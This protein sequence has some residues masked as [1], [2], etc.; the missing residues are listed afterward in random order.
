MIESDIPCFFI[1]KE[2]D[3]KRENVTNEVKLFYEN[4]PFPNY[5]GC[6]TLTDLVSQ[7]E[8]SYFPNWLN[9]SIPYKSKVLEI[10]CG[11]GLLSNYLSL[12]SRTVFGTDICNN[13]LDLANNFKLKNGIDR[14]GFY[15]MNLFYPVFKKESFDYIICNGVL[16]HTN[17]PIIGFSRISSLLKEDGYIILGLYNKYGRIIQ[18]LRKIINKITNIDI[19]IID[20]QLKKI[21]NIESKRKAWYLD[22][23]KHPHES[24]HTINEVIKWFNNNGINFINSIP[25]IG[26]FDNYNDKLDLFKKNS[27]PNKVNRIIAQMKLFFSGYREGGLFIM[28]G[29]KSSRL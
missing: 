3:E 24:T 11:T 19:S 17:D 16:H 13:S 23:Y 9:N 5:E 2:Q 10:G 14:V 20:P 7:A 1:S 22:Q 21:R 8:K 26:V 29:K 18:D 25:R 27:N 6:T 28:I 4:T 15:Q 12:G